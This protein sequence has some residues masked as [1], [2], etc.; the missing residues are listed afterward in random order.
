MQ[1]L[2]AMNAILWLVILAVARFIMIT[3]F[4]F[5]I[6]VTIVFSWCS[7]NELIYHLKDSGSNLYTRKFVYRVYVNSAILSTTE[8]ALDARVAASD[9]HCKK[10]LQSCKKISGMGVGFKRC[11]HGETAPFCA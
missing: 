10:F 4:A 1:E 2:L 9:P 3:E 11:D 7:V 6:L 8:L 5:C